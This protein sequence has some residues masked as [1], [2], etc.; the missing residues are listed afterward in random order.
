VWIEIGDP[1]CRSA[2]IRVLIEAG[3]KQLIIG[4]KAGGVEAD[5]LRLCGLCAGF[6]LYG[7]IRCSNL[8][9][10]VI[11]DGDVAAGAGDIRQFL[12][13]KPLAISFLRELCVKVLLPRAQLP[14]QTSIL[15]QREARPH[16]E[17][18][19]ALTQSSLS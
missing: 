10:A 1:E 9:L 13:Q 8:Q 4:D 17:R 7:E 19:R 6:C 18:T 12:Q 16:L 15:S 3:E 11:V 14:S 5:I 2:R